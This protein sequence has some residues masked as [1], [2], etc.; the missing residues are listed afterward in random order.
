MTESRKLSNDPFISLVFLGTFQPIPDL[1]DPVSSTL[2][3]F[4]PTRPTDTD[5]VHVT[6]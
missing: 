3:V 5:Q 1:P 6:V 4:S 2:R